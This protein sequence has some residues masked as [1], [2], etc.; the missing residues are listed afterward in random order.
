MRKLIPCLFASATLM[1]AP[2]NLTDQYQDTAKKLIAAAMDDRDGL[3]R[4]EYLCDRIGNRLSGSKSLEQAIVWAA[5]EMKKAGLENVQTPAVKVPH[6]VRGAESAVMVTPLERPISI[7]GLGGS[8]ATPAG[9]I[10]A[11]VISVTAFPELT[12]LGREKVAGKIV[13][14][15]APYAGYGQ[16]VMYRT[17]GAAAAAKMGAVASL[18]RSVTGLNVRVPHTGAMIYEDGVTKIPAAAVSVE[19]AMSITR[20]IKTGQKVTAKLIMEAHTEPDA[21]AANVVGEIRGS[22]KPDEYVV[23]GGHIDSWD[24]GQGAQ[25]DGSGIMAALEAASLIRKLGL[26]PKRSI[27]VVF[28]VNE[29]NGGAGGVAY[30]KWIGDGIKNT[31]AA[32]EMDGGA[33]KPAGFGLSAGGARRRRSAPSAPGAEDPTA[34]AGPGALTEA[35]YVKAGEIGKLLES[36]DAA[37][38]FRN[39]GGSDIGPLMADGVPGLGMQTVGTHYFD[40]HH[41]NADTFDKINPKDFKE[42]AAAMAVMSFVL[43]DMPDRL[44]EIK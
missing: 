35:A 36:I 13:L 26:K 1:A 21:D 5:A 23:M 9:G 18:T 25:D 6:W 4:F 38:I 11:E 42:C 15:D 43:A 31:V 28:W 12:E 3:D 22:E 34:A 10:T 33:E 41:T 30:R 14:F 37:R 20:L 2:A 19:D 44:T 40:W 8:I 29:E 24:V 16:T 7:L 39:G 27:R 32:I 17:G